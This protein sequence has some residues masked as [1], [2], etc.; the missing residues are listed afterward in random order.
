MRKLVLLCLLSWPLIPLAVEQEL[1]F[2]VYTSDKPSDM[3]HKFRPLLNDLQQ[4]LSARLEKT[5]VIHL[6]VLSSYEKGIQALVTGKID[7]ARFGPASYILSQQLN[8]DISLLAMESK[9]GKKTFNGIIAVQKESPYQQLSDLKGVRFA[10]GDK[11]STIGRYL[12]QSELL[13]AGIKA[14]DL[15]SFSYLGRHDKVGEVI[16]IGQYTA[17]S[18]KESSFKKLLDKG[19]NLRKL[20]EF[21]NVTKPWLARSGLDDNLLI[22]LR[23]I[24]LDMSG[25]LPAEEQ[26][27]LIIKQ[28]IDENA[29]FFQ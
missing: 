1:L 16:N 28:S 6:R 24:L 17:G 29:G 14:S 10:F 27:Y 13:K 15:A 12:A 5:I 26:D 4:R 2:G 23:Q 8:P 11:N 3:V 22:A 18:L 7:F 25:F 19:A 9:N 20:H 21:T